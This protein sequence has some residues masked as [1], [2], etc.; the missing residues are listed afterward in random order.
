MTSTIDLIGVPFDLGASVRGASMGAQALRIAGI[1][2][3]LAIL[4]HT[5]SDLGDVAARARPVQL[6]GEANHANAV[7]SIVNPL[8]DAV[9]QSLQQGHLPL[10][11]GGDH[12]ISFGSLAAAAR[13]AAHQGKPL[14]VLWLDAHADFNT[15]QTSPSGNM[16][17]MPVALIAGLPGFEGLMETAFPIVPAHQIT[18]IGVR[19]IDS[20][21]RRSVAKAGINL[22]DMRMV[23]EFGMA[24]LVRRTIEAVKRA[25]GML[26][27]SFDADFLDPSIAPG[28]GT[29][30]KGG[31]TWREAHL[32]MELLADSGLVSSLDLVE[33]NPFLDERGKTAHTLVDLTASLFGERIQETVNLQHFAN[34]NSGQVWQGMLQSV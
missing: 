10:I 11:M 21:E 6:P 22:F 8:Q 32:A 14:F 3:R 33:L 20:D 16:H 9:Y 5:V 15:P 18:M 2:E 31:A 7:A 29:D 1:G 28:V 25:S 24:V 19:S 17:G 13:H 30:V 12:S 27:V 26:H 34:S 23:D 4:G